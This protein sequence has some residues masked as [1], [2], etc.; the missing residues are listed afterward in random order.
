VTVATALNGCMVIL[1]VGALLCLESVLVE[2]VRLKRFLGDL[3]SA[4]VLAGICF[5]CVTLALWMIME[6][7]W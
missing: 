3:G 4:L 5:A 1:L 2:G 7:D 6:M